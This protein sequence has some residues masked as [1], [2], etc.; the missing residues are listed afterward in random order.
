MLSE[1]GHD[2]GIRMDIPI[3]NV[4]RGGELPDTAT[5]TC[6]LCRDDF[7]SFIIC[8]SF[9]F[10]QE[11]A[12]D[13]IPAFWACGVMPQNAIR[14]AKPKIFITHAPGSMLI[15]DL[16]SQLDSRVGD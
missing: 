11:F 6:G 12:N 16:P 15:N 9:S 13:E 2:I 7:V 8:C 14:M 10:K 3:Y 5:D 4:Y 1:L